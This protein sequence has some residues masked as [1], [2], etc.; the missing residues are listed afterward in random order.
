[1]PYGECMHVYVNGPVQSYTHACLVQSSPCCGEQTKSEGTDYKSV[2]TDL[3]IKFV[4]FYHVTPEGP[5]RITTF[6]VESF[7]HNASKIPLF[8][9][10]KTLSEK[11]TVCIF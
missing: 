1:M 4:F 5:R 9:N 8:T 10:G 7:N 3:H 6:K 11:C 2:R